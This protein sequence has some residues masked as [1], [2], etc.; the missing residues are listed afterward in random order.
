MP[1][2]V[3]VR[4]VQCTAGASK[5]TV[6]LGI[7]PE[8]VN[9]RVDIQKGGNDDRIPVHK[10]TTEAERAAYERGLGKGQQPDPITQTERDRKLMEG[11]A[12]PFS[13]PDDVP[14]TKACTRG[15]CTYRSGKKPN[16][17]E[18]GVIAALDFK[19]QHIKHTLYTTTSYPL[20]LN[21]PPHPDSFVPMQVLNFDIVNFA[22]VSTL[23]CPACREDRGAHQPLMFK[24]H[25]Q[26]RKVEC[27]DHVSWFVPTLYK[28]T[29]KRCG[30]TYN[31]SNAQACLKIGYKESM[32]VEYPAVLLSTTGYSHELYGDILEACV[33]HSLGQLVKR[34][35]RRRLDYYIKHKNRYLKYCM[36]YK[37]WL[38]VCVR[39]YVCVC[40]YVW[41]VCVYVYGCRYIC[42][43]LC[44]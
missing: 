41:Q 25:L 12:T 3:L 29:Y 38:R 17:R 40:V 9:V 23:S 15:N 6:V 10:H 28:C 44:V 19:D 14:V 37:Q 31:T 11:R 30:A 32:M 5:S 39:V 7:L 33:G 27:T 8:E 20:R 26:A 36:E 24:E 21:A 13:N 18:T 1:R 22:S 42:I 35:Q 43:Y 2:Q 34:L 16:A 4:D